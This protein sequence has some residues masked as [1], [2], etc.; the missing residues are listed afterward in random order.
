MVVWSKYNL[1][2][3][4]SNMFFMEPSIKQVPICPR[5]LFTQHEEV[6]YKMVRTVAFGH[7]CDHNN[8]KAHIVAAMSSSHV[9]DSAD[10]LSRFRNQLQNRVPVLS[11]VSSAKAITVEPVCLNDLIVYQ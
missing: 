6:L 1:T 10:A 2:V 3:F 7:C 5:Y 11:I 9:R 8:I 4:A